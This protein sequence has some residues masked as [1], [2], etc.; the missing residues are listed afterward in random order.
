MIPPRID[1]FW[2]LKYR[3][4]PQNAAELVTDCK[5][6][7]GSIVARWEAIALLTFLELAADDLTRKKLPIANQ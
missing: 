7:L 4:S 3:M 2:T 5:L 1:P 6:P